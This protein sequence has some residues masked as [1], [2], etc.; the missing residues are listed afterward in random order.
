MKASFLKASLCALA[1]WC[2]GGALGADNEKLIIEQ[3]LVKLPKGSYW[4]GY[5]FSDN[6]IMT[7][8]VRIELA[9]DFCGPTN[10]GGL[11]YTYAEDQVS[12]SNAQKNTKGQWEISNNAIRTMRILMNQPNFKTADCRFRVYASTL[13]GSGSEETFIG[14]LEYKGGYDPN[15]MLPIYPARKVKGFRIAVPSFCTGV[16]VL[17]AGVNVEGMFEKAKMLDKGALSYAVND[18]HGLVV[19]GISMKINGPDKACTVPIFVTE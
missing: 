17:E 4:I 9:G 16:D 13:M 11:I 2:A 18:G 5:D 14:V 12:W 1:F 7:S 10:I 19:S 15:L 6:P 3:N 8:A